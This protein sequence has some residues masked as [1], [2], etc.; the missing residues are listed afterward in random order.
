MTSLRKPLIT[1]SVA[2]CVIV[3]I[4][5]ADVRSI[6]T[7]G[8]HAHSVDPGDLALLATCLDSLSGDT[9]NHILAEQL[10]VGSSVY[11]WNGIGYDPPSIKTALHGWVP[12]HT[13]L[14]G[15]PIYVQNA[16]S[17]PG[18]VTFSF[19]GEVPWYNNGG[20]TTTVS[21]VGLEATAYPYPVDI[22]FGQT[23]AAIA[24]PINS[25]V[26]FWNADNQ[27][28]DSPIFKTPF[29]GWGPAETRL[30]P[31]G[32]AFFMTTPTPILVEEVVPYDL[33]I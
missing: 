30:I 22:E 6:N 7:V 10:P 14:R 8:Y 19:T 32:E 31:I 20:G 24:A 4:A 9:L 17:A 25:T 26:M 3:L 27:S 21:V 29:F 2:F 11:K 13:L 16:F 15:Q 12:N 28:F 23:Q 33:S 5:L 18:T 1:T